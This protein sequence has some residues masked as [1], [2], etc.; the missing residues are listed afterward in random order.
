MC[1]SPV[2][3]Q[4]RSWYNVHNSVKKRCWNLFCWLLKIY[5]AHIICQ[6]RGWPSYWVWCFGFFCRVQFLMCCGESKRER[7]QAKSI[8]M[9]AL[10]CGKV[11]AEQ[12]RCAVVCAS[13]ARFEPWLL[14]VRTSSALLIFFI[15][16]LPNSSLLPCT[17]F[18][19]QKLKKLNDSARCRWRL[20]HITILEFQK[21][22]ELHPVKV[23]WAQGLVKKM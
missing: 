16:C 15:P 8:K 3:E 12:T 7:L 22:R 11:L 17:F 21:G 10:L 5:L 1:S 23:Y 9:Y 4:V 2:G 14:G 19:S 18:T 6:M 20:I 13:K